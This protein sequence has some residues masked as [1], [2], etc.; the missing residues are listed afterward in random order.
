VVLD[1]GEQ[2]DKCIEAF[3]KYKP[4]ILNEECVKRIQVVNDLVFIDKSFKIENLNKDKI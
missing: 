3:L 2:T 4:K 1:C